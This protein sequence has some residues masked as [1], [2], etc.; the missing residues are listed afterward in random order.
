MNIK[1]IST[2]EGFERLQKSWQYL[3]DAAG[4][5]SPF[6]SWE[7]MFTWWQNYRQKLTQASL[8]VFCAYEDG[9][10][11]A[12]LPLFQHQKRNLKYIQFL[13]TEF[14][15]SDYLDLI[16][17]EENK[18]DLL[19]QF[20]NNSV[21]A[22]FIK[23]ADIL[24]FNNLKEESVLFN[25]RNWLSK[26]LS[27]KVY[28]RITSVCPYLPLPQS[29]DEVFKSL[30]RNMRSSLKRQRNKLA[31]N[32]TIQIQLLQNRTEVEEGIRHLF[33]LHSLRFKQKNM[34]TKFNYEKRGA[35]HEKMANVFL[36]KDWLQFYL[37]K[38]NENPIGAL[39]FYRLAGAMMYMQ[40]GFD[41]AYANL[42][43]GNQIILRA[44]SDA[45]DSKMQ[46]FDF[47]RGNEDYKKKWTDKSILLYTLAFPLSGK[48]RFVLLFR[49][50][51][52]V[53]KGW[54]KKA[55]FLDRK[56]DC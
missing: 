52:T 10:L 44:I 47:M 2:T 31:K 17:A 28:E 38:D 22:K 1:R 15:S 45:I 21:V 42:A 25:A 24:I 40:G 33:Y 16:C 51:V 30:S 26:N 35:F 5:N 46:T 48:G 20:I 49:E 11:T 37:I 8:A 34:A 3:F 18:A 23:S 53:L 50:N 41:P 7:W 43:L 55:I 14:E 9:E 39:Y 36:E 12:I 32:E 6:L 4:R 29:I 54:F 27:D 13:G 19:E 56:T